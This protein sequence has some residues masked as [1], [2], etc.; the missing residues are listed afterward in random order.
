MN[1]LTAQAVQSRQTVDVP[2]SPSSIRRALP[3]TNDSI[4]CVI[5]DAVYAP[6]PLQKPFLHYAGNALEAAFMTTCHFC[7]R[8]RRPACPQCWDG[9]HGICG[10]CVSEVDLP[11]RSPSPT[12]PGVLYP[13]VSQQQPARKAE[14][15]LLILVYPGRFFAI[16]GPAPVTDPVVAVR[17]PANDLPDLHVQEE[18]T[19]E[20]SVEAKEAGTFATEDM[21][22]EVAENSEKEDT[23]PR[24]QT[25]K[26]G[27]LEGTVTWLL[28]SLLFIIV[29]II[30]L[31]GFL[32]RVNELVLRFVHIDIRAEIAY[33][34]HIVQQMFK[35]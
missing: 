10:A 4:T 31:A 32:P 16:T 35:H 6:A 11:F 7:F 26:M 34:V 12:L 30:V 27:R 3:E 28:F 20:A 9:V 17:P 33:V 29:A 18:H 21:D 22:D 1:I 14:T 5:C 8:C 24:K 19:R 2:V 23:A 13:P 15:G 25:R